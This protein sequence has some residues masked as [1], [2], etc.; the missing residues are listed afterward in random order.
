M[1]ELVWKEIV[2]GDRIKKSFYGVA[3]PRSRA[4]IA[5][6]AMRERR[7]NYDTNVRIHASPAAVFVR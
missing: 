5:A 4:L 7:K 2:G 3:T 6:P 1:Q